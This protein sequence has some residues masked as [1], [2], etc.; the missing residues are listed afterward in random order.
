MEKIDSQSA[1]YS[2]RVVKNN[3]TAR[4]ESR[5]PSSSQVRESP[6]DGPPPSVSRLRIS[7]G[8]IVIQDSARFRPDTSEIRDTTDLE[9]QATGEEMIDPIE[10]LPGA[11]SHEEAIR[12]RPISAI[13]P[14]PRRDSDNTCSDRDPDGRGDREEAVCSNPP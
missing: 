9:I 13:S 6:I 7:S 3:D 12:E 10:T 5:E 2:S 1:E 14:R 8:P 11:D 4:L